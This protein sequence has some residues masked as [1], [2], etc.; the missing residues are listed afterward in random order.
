MFVNYILSENFEEN[1]FEKVYI[2]LIEKVCVNK[3][4]RVP[5][6]KDI[7]CCNF[8][9]SQIKVIQCHFNKPM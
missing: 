8:L 4:W 6:Y 5:Q 7:T 3:K 1:K 9:F 2:K